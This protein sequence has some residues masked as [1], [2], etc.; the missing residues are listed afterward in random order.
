[1]S[2]SASVVHRGSRCVE[3]ALDFEHILSATVSCESAIARQP[4]HQLSSTLKVVKVFLYTLYVLRF[5]MRDFQSESSELDNSK[6]TSHCVGFQVNSCV[7][8]GY[9]CRN[10]T[11]NFDT[12]HVCL[13]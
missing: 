10:I 12:I 3:G 4:A 1:M 8:I 5:V 6:W 2:S 13:V 7:A 11:V 9:Y